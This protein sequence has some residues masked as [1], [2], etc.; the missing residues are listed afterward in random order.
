M[1]KIGLVDDPNCDL[2]KVPQ[3]GTHFLMDCPETDDLRVKIKEEI[4]RRKLSVN[5]DFKSWLSN[6][7]IAEIIASYVRAQKLT[8]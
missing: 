5:G 8:V 4:K 2:C 6:P 7:H 1:F 3:D